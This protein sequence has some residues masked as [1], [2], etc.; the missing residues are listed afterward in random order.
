MK[1]LLLTTIAAVLVVGSAFADPIHD[2]A[3]W[4]N[5]AGV[6]AELD[7]GVDVNAKDEEGVTPMHY[8]ASGGNKEIAE[9][10][11][12]EGADVNAME[13]WGQTPL[14][15]AAVV[16]HKEIAE[17]LIANGSDLNAMEEDYEQTPLS[18]AILGS[19]KEIVELLIAKG[20]D[21][22]AKGVGE[23]TALHW[24]V[25]NV[26]IGTTNEKEIVELLIVKGADVNAKDVDGGTPLDWAEEAS[27]NEPPE[28]KADKKEIAELLRRHGGKT[29]EELWLM[30]RLVQHG[31]FAF[32]FDAKE[33]KVYEVQDS[34]DLLNWEVIKTYTGTGSSVR[35]DEERDHDP[36]KWFYRVRVVE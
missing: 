16:G 17:L 23:V 34:F 32:S 3:W 24:A 8:A 21:V 20:A 27:E 4:G 2:A 29:G 28:D 1:H 15:W 12:A 19:N 11:I 35:F 5:L 33:G 13:E 18:Y 36:P 10:L 25:S 7:K 30:P 14:H 9:L 6:Q 22:N 26:Q 31:R